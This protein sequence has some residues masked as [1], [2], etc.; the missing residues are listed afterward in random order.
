MEAQEWDAWCR[1]PERAFAGPPTPPEPRALREGLTE[2]DR[3]VS[4]RGGAPCAGT[5][6][7]SSLRLSV[8]GA[9]LV[10]TAGVTMASIAATHRSRG[11]M[12]AT[13][14]H[15]RYADPLSALAARAAEYADQVADRPCM[16]ARPPGSERPAVLVPEGGG[17]D[18]DSPLRTSTLGAQNR[19][20][21]GP[22]RPEKVPD[23]A[24]YGLW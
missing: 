24:G 16:P 2:H 5:A 12:T 13:M 21:R 4:A 14:R 10:D 6:G 8:P 7:A 9:A 11:P 22:G 15:Q 23:F 20:V 19:P 18:G 3:F 17:R 1:T